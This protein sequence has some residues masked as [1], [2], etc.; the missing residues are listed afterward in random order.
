MLL[1]DALMEIINGNRKEIPNI[2][3]LG[4]KGS[5]KTYLYRQLIRKK[6]WGNFVRTLEGD[7][8]TGEYIDAAVV[9][10]FATTNDK[11]IIVDIMECFT[12]VDRYLGEDLVSRE[13]FGEFRRAVS[14]A[15]CE[16]RTPSEW[17]DIWKKQ[18]LGL[19]SGRLG[20]ERVVKGT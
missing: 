2:V 18:I 11:N 1:T 10:V 16:K 20:I 14:N 12:D 13:R 7:R 5:G 19:F 8:Q 6:T 15:L 4:A 17:A 9:P 3:V